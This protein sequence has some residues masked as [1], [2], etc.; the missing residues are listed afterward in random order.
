M[1]LLVAG[2]GGSSGSDEAATGPATVYEVEGTDLKRI[3]LT[4]A[5]A[6]RL[7]IQTMPVERNGSGTVIPYAAVFYSPTGETWA[8]VSPRPLT[9]VRR[10]IVVEHID[11]DRAILSK[12]PTPGTNVVTVGVVELYG[13]ESGLGE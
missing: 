10:A 1:A 3:E 13:V 9:F 11:G 12:G 5:A 4:E 8:Y 7:D 2:C 6:E